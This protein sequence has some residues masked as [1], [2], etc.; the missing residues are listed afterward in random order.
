[1]VPNSHWCLL[2]S[3]ARRGVLMPTVCPLHGGVWQ[4]SLPDGSTTL[5]PAAAA[6]HCPL[7]LVGAQ[8]CPLV[9]TAWYSLPE[10]CPVVFTSSQLCLGLTN[11]LEILPLQ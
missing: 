3:G 8:W 1:M 2:P 9:P 4:C 5:V 10:Q 6:H 11:I 7:V